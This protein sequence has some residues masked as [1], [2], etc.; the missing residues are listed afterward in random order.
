MG[1]QLGITKII[2]AAGSMDNS[3]NDRR[4]QVLELL[5][6][7]GKGLQSTEELLI[8][9]EK[10]MKFVDG[11]QSDTEALL[12]DKSAEPKAFALILDELQ[13]QTLHLQKIAE[14]GEQQLL[15]KTN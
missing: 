15:S 9:A 6:R 2:H 7:N 13:K 11:G 1:H 10:I 4:L 5:L 8:D 14:F 3:T 12:L